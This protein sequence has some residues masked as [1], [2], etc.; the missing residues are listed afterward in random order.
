MLLGH[1]PEIFALLVLGLLVFGPRKM[2][3]MG[4]SLGKA[5]REFRES[6][7]D[8][9]WNELTGFGSSTET[10]RQT[11]LSKLSQFSQAV[12]VNRANESQPTSPPAP[13]DAVVE[14]TVELEQ[15]AAPKE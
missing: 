3:E 5:V 4:S 1:L 7:K 8:L 9:S 11:A 6:T 15:D 14:G 12:G 10:P 13:A 2:I